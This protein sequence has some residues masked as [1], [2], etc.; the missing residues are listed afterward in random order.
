MFIFKDLKIS[1]IIFK[2]ALFCLFLFSKVWA[3]L[4]NFIGKKL[5]SVDT[6]LVGRSEGQVKD[7]EKIT[8]I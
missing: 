4:T 5:G 7:P 8:K 6:G 2:L 3:E 1:Y